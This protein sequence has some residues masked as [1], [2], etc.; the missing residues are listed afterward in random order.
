MCDFL[1]AHGYQVIMPDYFRGTFVDP[2]TS[3]REETIEFLK[4]QSDWNGRLK[5]DYQKVKDFGTSMGC[6]NFGTIGTCWGTYRPLD[7]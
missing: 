7:N 4:E 1:A 6:Q 3:P 5:E 2:S